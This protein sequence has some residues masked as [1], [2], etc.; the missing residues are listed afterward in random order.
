[1]LTH[2]HEDHYG[3]LIDLWPKLKIPVYATPFTAACSLQARRRARRAG[4][5][6]DHRAARQPFQGGAIRYRAGLDGAFDSGIER[7][8]H[9]HACGT[10]LHTGDWKI[11]LTPILGDVTDEKKLRALGRRLPGADRDSTNAVREGRSPSEADVGKTISALIK[12][13]RG[14]VAVIPRLQCG[15]LAHGGGGGAYNEREVVVVAAPWSA[16]CRLRVRPAIS[17]ACSHFGPPMPMAICAEQSRGAVY[18][19]PGANR[20]RRSRVLPPTSIRSDALARRPGD[21]FART[22]PATKRS[23]PYHQRADRLGIEVI[24]DAPT[25]CTCPGI[26]AAP[27]S[28]N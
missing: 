5:S 4:N 14:R 9:P 1:V 2:A 10:V 13:A 16:S 3:A 21:L 7:A 24:T 27:S 19:Q 23:R 18:R 11:D 22:I 17:K 12:S 28:R 6:G 25:W 20:A 26:R 8:H 15:A